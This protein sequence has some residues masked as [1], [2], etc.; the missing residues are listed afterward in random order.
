MLRRPPRSTRAD[1]LFPYPTLGRSRRRLGGGRCGA[2]SARG[3]RPCRRR[4][5][6]LYP[7]ARPAGGAHPAP[8]LLRAG[9]AGGGGGR[10]RGRGDG[11]P[12]ALPWCVEQW[13]VLSSGERPRDGRRMMGAGNVR[14]SSMNWRAE[15]LLA[16][17][18]R[19][20]VGEGKSV[21][22]RVGL[23]GGRIM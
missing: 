12:W 10:R 3:G 7:G 20:R 6:S 14:C 2:A 17:L 13:R 5:Q 18:D 22:V 21:V 23:G 4:H 8:R 9:R 16:R 1:T 15:E 19:E 11:A